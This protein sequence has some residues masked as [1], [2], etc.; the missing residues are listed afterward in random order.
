MTIR[1]DVAVAPRCGARSGDALGREAL[2]AAKLLAGEMPQTSRRCSRAR[3]VALPAPAAATCSTEC[4]CPDWSNPCKHIAAV[5]YLL[6]E[7][8]D[9]DPFLIFRLR[10]LSREG[11]RALLDA[12][13]ARK[14]ATP[15]APVPPAAPPEP[16]AVSATALSPEPDRVL[17]RGRTAS[18]RRGARSRSAARAPDPRRALPF[19]RGA[20]PLASHLERGLHR[21]V[22]AGVGLVPR[23]EHA[24]RG[25]DEATAA[26]PEA[27]ARR[28]WARSRA[29]AAS[30]SRSFGGAVVT[31]EASRRW[32]ESVTSATAVSKAA[33]LALDGFVDPEILRTNCR[34][35]LRTSASVTG[36]SKLNSGRMFRHMPLMINEGRV[37]E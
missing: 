14:G 21:R 36:G 18:R 6:G 32:Q 16:E 15:P 26:G 35:A 34:A 25:S 10:G 24:A 37:R 23:A 17:V 30:T 27:T 29:L 1:V 4:S 2:F 8:F 22:A 13:S 20:A 33:S 3:A 31:I 12:E 19:W 9:R 28:F 11:L 5:Y 7:E